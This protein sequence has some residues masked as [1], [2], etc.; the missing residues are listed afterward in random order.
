MTVSDKHLV[1]AVITLASTHE[2]SRTM[3]SLAVLA[4]ATLLLALFFQ[5][6]PSAPSE[7]PEAEVATEG[8]AA[9]P[10]ESAPEETAAQPPPAEPTPTSAP[11]SPTSPPPSPA[12]ASAPVL[13]EFSGQG[14][15]ATQLYALDAGLIR[16]DYTYAG[17]HNFIVQVLDSQG[18]WAAVVANEIGSCEGSSAGTIGSPGDYLLNVTAAGDWTVRCEANARGTQPSPWQPVVIFELAGLGNEATDFVHLESGVLRGDYTYAGEHNFIVEVL[19]SQGNWAAVIANEIGS[20]EGSTV[21]SIASAGD[22][23]SNVTADGN[24]TVRLSQ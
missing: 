23:L 6:C 16:C 19:D 20:C 15:E 8:A 24:W 9:P 14:N 13:F 1:P 7:A 22:Y 12:P 17:E 4:M 21:A 10:A 3:K 2:R 5:C 11:P 18:N